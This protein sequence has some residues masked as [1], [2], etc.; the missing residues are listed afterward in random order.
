M[1]SPFELFTDAWGTV[2]GKPRVYIIIS[3]VYVGITASIILLT[4]VDPLTLEND[5][6]I[7]TPELIYFILS[8]CISILAYVTLTKAIVS[9]SDDELTPLFT[10]S[11]RMF[12]P[13][14]WVSILVGF[15]IL[16]GFLL[17]II[18][19]IY[20]MVTFLFATYILFTENVRGQEALAR[21]Y[22]YVKG[23]WFSVFWRLLFLFLPSIAFGLIVGGFFALAS[24]ALPKLST[25]LY[26]ISAFLNMMFYSI[27]FV[28]IYIMYTDIRN[29]YVVQE[30]PDIQQANQ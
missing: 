14:M 3:A 20:L 4:G 7:T 28:Y 19:G 6:I 23:R 25:L 16:L 30:T 11:L 12:F 1:R 21:S 10:S 5:E 2:M 9:N 22:R 24:I 26:S 27:C 18:P 17:L 8:G 13:Y 29:S 15:A